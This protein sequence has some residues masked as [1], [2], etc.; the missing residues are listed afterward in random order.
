MKKW[1]EDELEKK[2]MYGEIQHEI[3]KFEEQVT[4]IIEE[5]KR[6]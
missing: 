1:K 5:E 3:E 2:R 6:S 4:D